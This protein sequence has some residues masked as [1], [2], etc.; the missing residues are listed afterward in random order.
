MPTPA[1]TITAQNINTEIGA[2]TTAQMALNDTN[3]RGLARVITPTSLISY[4]NL[5]NKSRAMSFTQSGA[6]LNVIRNGYQVLGWEGSRTGSFSI[7]TLGM[8]STYNTIEF[9]ACA[10]GGGGGGQNGGD[11]NGGG[12]GG[13]GELVVSSVIVPNTG[14]AINVIVGAGGLRGAN[15]NV[16]GS[17]GSNTTI[18]GSLAVTCRGGGGGGAGAG[19]RDGV[20]GGSGG[21]VAVY[22]NSGGTPGAATAVS[23]GR[24]FPG[25]NIYNLSITCLCNSTLFTRNPQRPGGGG[26]AGGSTTTNQGGPGFSS[27]IYSNG[28]SYEFSTGGNAAPAT[29]SRVSSWGSGGGGMYWESAIGTCNNACY[30]ASTDGIAGAVII[31]FPV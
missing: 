30:V 25:G 3:V 12:G 1:G 19:N 26:G 16:K 22:V 13:A 20:A 7:T 5:Q 17:N 10:G 9:I 2:A 24:G 4:N 18:T 21:G 8:N 23:P 31:R 15:T 6:T 28:G 14:W 27:N 29:G 11:G